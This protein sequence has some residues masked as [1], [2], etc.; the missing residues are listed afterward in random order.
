MSLLS[1]LKTIITS[2]DIP[3]ETGVFSEKA[4]DEYIV[5]VPIIDEFADHADNKPHSEVQ[6]VRIS[7]YTKNSYTA[8]KSRVVNAILKTDIVLTDGQYIG[9][10]ENTKYHHYNLDVENV[11]KIEMEE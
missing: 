1:D 8:M 11:Y 10:E 6:S 5:L 9:F 3:V 7:M 2:L 4:P